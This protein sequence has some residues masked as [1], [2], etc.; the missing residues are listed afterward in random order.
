[1]RAA[2]VSGPHLDML[3]LK[4]L[5]WFTREIDPLFRAAY[6]A[7]GRDVGFLRSLHPTSF[8][9]PVSPG[10]FCFVPAVPACVDVV[11]IAKVSSEVK[12]M[13]SDFKL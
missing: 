11:A 4:A 13:L 8:P 5:P 7:Y 1:M 6:I 9:S 3:D 12:R 10:L 2:S